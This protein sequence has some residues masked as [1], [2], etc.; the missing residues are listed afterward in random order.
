MATEIIGVVFEVGPFSDDYHFINSIQEQRREPL[1]TQA[2]TVYQ[3][4]GENH[5]NYESYFIKAATLLKVIIHETK[6]TEELGYQPGLSTL[7][8]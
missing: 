3:N 6:P 4:K 8:G 2:L 1:L 7:A 5:C